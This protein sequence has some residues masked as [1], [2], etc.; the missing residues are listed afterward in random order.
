MLADSGEL[1]AAA[2]RLAPGVR[3]EIV[4]WGVD[5]DRY[6]PDPGARVAAR[7]RLGVDGGPAC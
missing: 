6:R 3:V 2:R 1:A 4:Q 7:Q 5:L